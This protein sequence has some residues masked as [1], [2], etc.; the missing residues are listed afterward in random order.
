MTQALTS[1]GYVPEGKLQ[2]TCPLL[3]LEKPGWP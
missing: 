3:P 2:Q 1:A